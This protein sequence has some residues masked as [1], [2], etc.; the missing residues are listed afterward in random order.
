MSSGQRRAELLATLRDSGREHSN[1]LV[2][3]HGVLSER[4]GL[5]AIEEK[6]L[7][8]LEREGP[9][10]A[11]QLATRTGL[12]PASITGLVD[13]LARKNFVRRVPHEVDRRR[14]NVEINQEHVGTFAALFEDLTARFDNLYATYSDEEL[15]LIVDYVQQSVKILGAATEALAMP[16]EPERS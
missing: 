12:A 7:D 14:V 6:T 3:F 16:A 15:E 9:L 13:R 11:G 10:T 1:A 8:L 5:S 4:M 2:M